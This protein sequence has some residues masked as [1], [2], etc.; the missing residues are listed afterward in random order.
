[1]Y[2]DVRSLARWLGISHLVRSYMCYWLISESGKLISKTSVKHITSDDILSSWTKQQIDIF[3]TKLEERLNDTS[4]M[5]DGVAGFDSAH[6]DDIK[7]N[8]ENPGGVSDQGITPTHEDYGEMNIGER[9]EVD[10][11]EAVDKYL[12]VELILDVG[13]ENKR[14]GRVA[15]RL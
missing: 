7:D 12:N 5:V 10:D 11:E 13:S 1:M 15:K 6:L 8:Q 3:N 14:R 4:F 9:S 2:D